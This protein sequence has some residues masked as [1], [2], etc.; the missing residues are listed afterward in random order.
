[1]EMNGW[2]QLGVVDTIYED[3][4]EDEEDCFNSLSHSPSAVGSPSNRSDLSP[5]STLRGIVEAWSR[6]KGCRPDVIVRVE[7]QCF[8]LHKDPVIHRC[9]YLKRHL[10]DSSDI[11]IKLPLGLTA[12]AFSLV[13]ISCYNNDVSLTPTN[14]TSVHAAAEWLEI[15]NNDTSTTPYLTTLIEDYF[16][17]EVTTESA[18]TVEVLKSCV[19]LFGGEASAPA[20]AFFA[21]C[22]EVLAGSVVAG[23]EWLDDVAALPIEEMQ[24]VADEMH[25]RSLH[26][27]DLLYRIVDHYLENHEGKLS[28]E[29][30]AR[31]CYTITCSSL[32]PPLFMHL[33]Q[34]P[35]LPL[36]FIVQAMLLD[37]LQSHHSMFLHHRPTI[38]PQIKPS[39]LQHP[40]PTPPAQTLGAILQRDALLRQSAHLRASMEATSFRIESLEREM[41]GLKR[42]L[43]RSDEAA[44]CES[45][46]TVSEITAK[47]GD[48]EGKAFFGTR[49]V[50]GFK[51][52]FK[53]GGGASA[54][55]RKLGVVGEASAGHR[56]NRSLSG[57]EI[58]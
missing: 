19:K 18:R 1:M 46:R 29:E 8:R 10:T 40:L 20:V 50:Q 25:E 43:R 22:V 39:Q 57:I 55:C 36:R 31:L 45:F 23:E 24:A 2:Q 42:C 26:D 11:T 27:H 32:S 9:G 54:E 12:D 37:Q 16:F 34:N 41:A 38:T 28:E 35:H 53:K 17:Q 30:K 5:P 56:R 48:I 47:S 58:A 6:E 44:R 21:R 13:I 7:D 3:Q 49:L 51:R 4:E 15:S 14:L 33:V 52:F